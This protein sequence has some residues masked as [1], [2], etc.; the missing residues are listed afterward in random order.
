MSCWLWPLPSITSRKVGAEPKEFFNN[1]RLGARSGTTSC[2][3]TGR[4]NKTVGNARNV[5]FNA[6]WLDHRLDFAFTNWVVDFIIRTCELLR[7]ICSTRGRGLDTGDLDFDSSRTITVLEVHFDRSCLN[8]WIVRRN[9]GLDLS[10][11]F[12]PRCRRK[13]C[14]KANAVDDKVHLHECGLLD[15]V[16]VCICPE[17]LFCLPISFLN[18]SRV[19][20]PVSLL[21]VQFAICCRVKDTEVP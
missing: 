13:R 9:H 18:E 19:V 15:H 21:A 4:W 17:V 16:A 14:V 20:D 5:E 11:Q 8:R 3:P 1:W 7:E 6:C 12:F 2:G 10:L